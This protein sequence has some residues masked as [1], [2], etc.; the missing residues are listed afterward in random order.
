[1]HDYNIKAFGTHNDVMLT[2]REYYE[3][4]IKGLPPYHSTTMFFKDNEIDE[5]IE[6]LKNYAN[7][8]RN[9]DV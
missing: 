4:P 2:R 7:E 3:K 9:K 6:V 5:L 1:M 8:R